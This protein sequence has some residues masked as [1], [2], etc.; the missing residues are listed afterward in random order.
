MP[1]RKVDLHAPAVRLP[2]AEEVYRRFCATP[3]RLKKPRVPCASPDATQCPL[4]AQQPPVRRSPARPQQQRLTGEQAPSQGA[5]ATSPQQKQ[6]QTQTSTVSV[7]DNQKRPLDEAESVDGRQ[8]TTTR[9][10]APLKRQRTTTEN[11]ENIDVNIRVDAPVAEAQVSA[12]IVRVDPVDVCPTLEDPAIAAP[13]PRATP[14]T[15]IKQL[16]EPTPTNRRRRQAPKRDTQPQGQRRSRRLLER[17]QCEEGHVLQDPAQPA[18]PINCVEPTE[19]SVV[20]APT[21]TI[22]EASTTI[23]FNFETEFVEPF[24]TSKTTSGDVF[25]EWFRALGRD[26]AATSGQW[27]DVLTS[28]HFICMRISMCESLARKQTE[29]DSATA[30]TGKSVR[31]R[32][33]DL[34]SLNLD[35]S[36]NSTAAT[37]EAMLAHYEDMRACAMA[38]TSTPEATSVLSVAV[39]VLKTTDL[40]AAQLSGSQTEFEACRRYFAHEFFNLSQSASTAGEFLDH[41]FSVLSSSLIRYRLRVLFLPFDPQGLV[42]EFDHGSTIT[43]Y[44]HQDFGAAIHCALKH[45]WIGQ[46]VVETVIRIV[47]HAEKGPDASWPSEKAIETLKDVLELEDVDM[48]QQYVGAS[49]F[50][51]LSLEKCILDDENTDEDTLEEVSSIE[52]LCAQ[53]KRL[54]FQDEAHLFPIASVSR[55]YRDL[56]LRESTLKNLE[57][58]VASLNISRFGEFDVV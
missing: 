27:H 51:V 26:A 33:F 28:L 49:R 22:E 44:D 47:D 56:Q 58:I 42:D 15:P 53:A 19:E 6:V 17:G 12:A 35:Y 5:S 46:P 43:A 20:N 14:R 10:V 1:T 4:A 16:S 41:Q 50:L 45:V 48:I 40:F 7:D 38:I 30:S 32:H 34:S 9:D 29:D 23:L 36:E 25:A 24:N 8:S 21:A 31:F 52:R 55:L 54:G 2:G 37:V 18:P 3:L 13:S 11:K 57:M 39:A